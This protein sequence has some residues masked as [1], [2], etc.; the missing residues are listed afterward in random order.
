MRRL[1]SAVPRVRAAKPRG[2]GRGRLR[3]RERQDGV[4]SEQTGGRSV[5]VPSS[6]LVSAG[7]QWPAHVAI[8]MD[9][10]G[11]WAQ[12]RGLPRSKGHEAGFQRAR[13][14]I[15]A[16]GEWGIPYLT[17]YA[18]STENWRRPA[19]EVSFLMGLLQRAIRE[20]LQELRENNIR[21][22]IL[23]RLQNLPAALAR[24][25]KEAEQ[26]TA[27]NTGLHLNMAINY[28]GRAEIVDA[29]RAIAA[30]VREGRLSP[31]EIDETCLARHLYTAG[32]PDPE[33]IIRPSGE[34][35]LSNFLLWQAAYAEFY[36]TDVLWPD[37]TREHLLQALEEFTHRQR[38]FG[39]I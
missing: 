36:V 33:L 8:I 34:M 20:E 13:D 29:A 5:G 7:A 12:Q 26:A 4:M 35:R 37:F 10:N 16:C 18:F 15:R 30:E 23:G 32:Q 17:L 2:A 38:R 3:A 24:G 1:H 27:G 6:G 22:R 31:E 21:L 25:L 14:I 39:G 11:R 9:G 28:G 19:G